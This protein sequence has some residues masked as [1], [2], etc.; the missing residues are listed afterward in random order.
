MKYPKHTSTRFDAELTEVCSSVQTMG[1]SVEKQIRLAIDSLQSGDL[2]I[3]DRVL[4]EGHIV[5]AMEVSIDE[6]CTQI[7]VKRQP[8]ANDLRLVTTIIKT[9]NDLESIGDE[10]ENISRMSKQISIK[11]LRH[12]PRFQQLNYAAD[13]AL[14]ML[15]DGLS[16]FETLDA[17]AAKQVGYRDSLIDDEFRSILRHLMAYMLEDSSELST[18]LQV[19]FI[20]KAI[21]RI[22]DHAKNISEYVVYMIEGREAR[23]YC[24]I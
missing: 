20:A 14:Q 15:M 7:L 4:D 1:L 6:S 11:N 8:T 10:A 19:I 2:S 24:T 18:A 12:I 21:E 23:N 3:I 9:I 13:L 17:D 16:A 22:G 5:N